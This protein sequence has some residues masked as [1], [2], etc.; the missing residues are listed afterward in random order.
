MSCRLVLRADLRMQDKHG[1]TALH[2]A[3]ECQQHS[4]VECLL[5]YRADPL[6]LEYSGRNCFFLA[7]KNND[8]RMLD[9]LSE[10]VEPEDLRAAICAADGSGLT[11]ISVCRERWDPARLHLRV[12]TSNRCTPYLGSCQRMVCHMRR[13]LCVHQ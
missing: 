8:T 1:R 5:D 4:T 10:E 12:T 2:W 9:L 6:V 13:T 7:A 11:P 3:V